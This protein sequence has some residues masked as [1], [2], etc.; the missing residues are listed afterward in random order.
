MKNKVLT[1]D[2]YDLAKIVVVVSCL[3]LAGCPSAVNQ[4]NSNA[5]AIEKDGDDGGSSY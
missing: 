1:T 5:I 3:L 2:L 4:D